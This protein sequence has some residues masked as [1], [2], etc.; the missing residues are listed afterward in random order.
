MLYANWSKTEPWIVSGVS[1]GQVILPGNGYLFDTPEGP[2]CSSTAHGNIR[3]DRAQ[4]PNG[5]YVDGRGREAT[6]GPLT[7]CGSAVLL[8]DSACPGFYRLIDGGGN[9]AI[10]IGRQFA[11]SHYRAISIDNEVLADRIADS[12]DSGAVIKILPEAVRYE[13]QG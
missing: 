7:A 9:T 8:V 4:T 12:D 6:S 11:P 3:C 10:R 1:E 5:W 13:W 2:L